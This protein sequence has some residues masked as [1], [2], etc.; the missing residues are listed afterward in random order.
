MKNQSYGVTLQTEKMY[1]SLFLAILRK[2]RSKV[3]MT[4]PIEHVGG[5]SLKKP[6]GKG[7]IDVSIG[8][9]N[10]AERKRIEGQLV[11]IFG[12]PAKRRSDRTR[13]NYFLQ[14]VEIEIQLSD[15]MRLNTAVALRE[16]LNTYPSEAKRYAQ[17]IAELRKKF[18]GRMYVLKSSFSK[19]ALKVK[20]KGSIK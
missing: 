12:K 20:E 8:Y 4:V 1:H 7:D 16:Y 3:S 13:F 2:I 14:G 17:G 6:S 15:M 5:T 11:S 18:L 19:R 10:Q 9:K